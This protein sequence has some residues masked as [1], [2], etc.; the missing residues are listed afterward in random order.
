MTELT[1][2]SQFVLVHYEFSPFGV[3]ISLLGESVAASPFRFSCEYED[4]SL[5]LLYYNFRNYDIF[6]ARWM[7]RDPL[8]E[9]SFILS[10]MFYR[11]IKAQNQIGNEYLYVFNKGNSFYDWIGLDNPGC[12]IPPSVV[13]GKHRDCLRRCCAKHDE[14]Y[15]SRNGTSP[16]GKCR[17]TAG[18]WSMNIADVYMRMNGAK[19]LF[20]DNPCKKCNSDVV[21]CFMSC[22][23]GKE[24]DGPRWFCPNGDHAG[25][26]YDRWE[27]IPASCFESGQKPYWPPDEDPPPL[28]PVPYYRPSIPEVFDAI[29]NL[30]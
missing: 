23:V 20:G 6:C 29:M 9:R 25:E 19:D 22:Y 16:G 4:D 5:S 26:F 28:P 14:C 12:D 30:Q 21:S 1:T 7:N 27:D 13:N 24:G 15:F 10:F 11:V 17:C 3:V 18:S 8:Y 2:S